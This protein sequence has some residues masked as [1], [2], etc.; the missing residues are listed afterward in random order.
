MPISSSSRIVL[1]TLLCTMALAGCREETPDVEFLRPV[2]VMTVA[3]ASGIVERSFP[4]RAAA[5]EEIELSFRVPGTLIQRPIDVGDTVSAGQLVAALDPDTFTADVE[6]SQAEVAA[7]EAAVERTRLELERQQKLL[8]EGWVTEARVETV[9]AAH[10]NSKASLL[11]AEAAK[12]RA[13]L[14]LDYT[15]LVAPFD[16]VVVDVYAENFQEVQAKQRVARI[17]DTSRIEFWVSLPEHLMP[18][19]DFVEDLAVEFDAYPGEALPA[20]VNE[21]SNEASQTTRAFDVNLVMDQPEG[22]TVLPG[23]AGRATGKHSTAAGGGET[24]YELPLS[25]IYNPAG[26][27]SFVWIF[28]EGAGAVSLREVALGETTRVGV[29]VTGIEP[30]EKIVTAGVEYLTDGQKVKMLE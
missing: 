27:G 5:T 19:L 20:V 8:E 9:Q 1:V 22:F 25:A 30:G 17:V 24:G 2:R 21:I 26:D 28:D 18:Q 16:G 3:D 7:A 13:E 6:R 15:S 29:R 10:N 11:A 4:G 23:M 12:K 14:D